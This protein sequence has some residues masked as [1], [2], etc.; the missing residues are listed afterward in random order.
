M[1]TDDTNYLQRLNSHLFRPNRARDALSRLTSIFEHNN[2]FKNPK[3]KGRAMSS[4]GG[5]NS[6]KV[7]PY[8]H[9]HGGGE[10]DKGEHRPPAPDLLKPPSAIVSPRNKTYFQ[11][12]I[13][14]KHLPDDEHPILIKNNHG[15]LRDFVKYRP[16]VTDAM[17]ITSRTTA[18]LSDLFATNST[19]RRTATLSTSKET[20]SSRETSN[21]DVSFKSSTLPTIFDEMIDTVYNSHSHNGYNSATSNSS[22]NKEDDRTNVVKPIRDW[23]RDWN[24][25]N[26]HHHHSVHHA[27]NHI[28]HT[29]VNELNH[30]HMAHLS[31][32]PVTVPKSTASPMANHRLTTGATHKVTT[33]LAPH[34]TPAHV[35]ITKKGNYTTNNSSKYFATP[36][37]NLEKKKPVRFTLKPFVISTHDT[38]K[39]QQQPQQH[40]QAQQ[41]SYSDAPIKVN[42]YEDLDVSYSTTAMPM[43]SSYE[44]SNGDLNI[45]HPNHPQLI[46]HSNQ[47][48]KSPS[49]FSKNKFNSTASLVNNS[50]RNNTKL[51]NIS[52]WPQKASTAATL[53]ATSSQISQQTTKQQQVSSEQQSLSTAGTSSEEDDHTFTQLQSQHQANKSPFQGHHHSNFSGSVTQRPTLQVTQL[54]GVYTKPDSDLVHSDAITVMDHDS[55]SEQQQQQSSAFNPHTSTTIMHN[56]LVVSYKLGRPL[57]S[58]INTSGEQQQQQFSTTPSF[59]LQQTNEQI[60]QTNILNKKPDKSKLPSQLSNTKI[61]QTLTK[62]PKPPIKHKPSPSGSSPNKINQVSIQQTQSSTPLSP[63]RRVGLLPFN[64]QQQTIQQHETQQQQVISSTHNHTSSHTHHH[65]HTTGHQ[66]HHHSYGYV[67]GE[68][69]SFIRISNLVIF[70]SFNDQVLTLSYLNLQPSTLRQCR[71]CQFQRHHLILCI[72]IRFSPGSASTR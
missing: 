10:P 9:K 3:P 24:R 20:S 58:T 19:S 41:P 56:N 7:N 48:L 21:E 67:N 23:N 59:A 66:N 34:R 26:S 8:L 17:S 6:P 61:N 33:L 4:G 29:L 30:N 5:G 50:Q 54:Q 62:L 63:P 13:S 12:F 42:S 46:V 70:F 27:N 22:L 16:L 51:A 15:K 72:G 69:E 57:P 11:Q 52:K 38:D 35:I 25:E 18:S 60:S 2:P 65:N 1:S 53:A 32:S 49:Q 64:Q 55:S 14:A 28:T 36:S 45:K 43:D 40:Q 39:K 37:Y 44:I 31:S 47:H 68:L 71:P